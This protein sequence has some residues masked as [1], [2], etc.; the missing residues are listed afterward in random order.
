[1][2]N[3][4]FG[5]IS[6]LLLIIIIISGAFSDIVNFFLWLFLL[7][8]SSPDVSLEGE[9]VVRVLTFF[10]SYGLVGVIFTTFGF[11]NSKLMSISYFIV[12]TLI[13]FLIARAVWAF[14][15]NIKIIN[16][17][18]ASIIVATIVFFIIYCIAK[19]RRKNKIG[20]EK[21]E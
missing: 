21:D 20:G 8:N 5:V 18:F 4:L 13:G 11:F 6:T 1:M 16:I 15:Q 7:Q 9:I 17:I 19:K 2:N 10:V 3:K 14:E 12:S